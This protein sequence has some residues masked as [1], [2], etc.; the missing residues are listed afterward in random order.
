MPTLYVLEPGS[1]LEKEYSRLLVTKDDEVLMRV[2]IGRVSQVVLIGWTG[3]TTPAMHALLQREI[4]VLLVRRSGKLLGRLLPPT[5]ANLPLRQEQY[6][7]NDDETFCLELARA[8]VMGKIRNQRTL[9]LR[10]VRRHNHIDIL[11]I[12]LGKTW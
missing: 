8:I 12:S 4:P 3:M 9:A 10:L 1:R 7:R 11:P 5:A 6:R 2:P